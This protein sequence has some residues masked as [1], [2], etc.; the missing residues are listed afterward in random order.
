[1]RHF[2][3]S[4]ILKHVFVSSILN[5]MKECA[6]LQSLLL[7]RILRLKN[8][9]VVDLHDCVFDELKSILLAL[10]FG[11][12]E[13]A[14]SS[15]MQKRV[16]F[17]FSLEI[18]EHAPCQVFRKLR[19]NTMAILL[20]IVDNIGSFLFATRITGIYINK[21]NNALCHLKTQPVQSRKTFTF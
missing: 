17:H 19:S 5:L 16:E 13:T 9:F 4:A 21:P 7:F 18:Y 20:T 11:L 10:L 8:S 6:V 1:M 12:D 15:R 14:A 3:I 2:K